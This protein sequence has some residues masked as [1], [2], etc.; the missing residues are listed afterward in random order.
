MLPD[1]C[2]S[3]SLLFRLVVPPPSLSAAM[4]TAGVKETDPG[5]TVWSGSGVSPPQGSL[6]EWV[7][8]EVC[9]NARGSVC[10]VLASLALMDMSVLLIVGLQEKNVY[11]LF[12]AFIILSHRPCG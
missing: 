9:L 6:G 8:A 1:V 10:P 11:K 2:C 4:S 5:N 12:Y 7:P 3:P